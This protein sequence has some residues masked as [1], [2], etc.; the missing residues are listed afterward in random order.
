MKKKKKKKKITQKKCRKMFLEAICF[1][2]GENCFSKFPYKI[3][4]IALHDTIGLKKFHCLSA[5]NNPELR[6]VICTGL[7]LFALVLHFLRW[8]AL[9]QS[10]SSIFSCVLLVPLEIEEF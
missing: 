3:F 4:V 1:R 10:E 5:N 8:L 2:I 9:S 6:C 7:I